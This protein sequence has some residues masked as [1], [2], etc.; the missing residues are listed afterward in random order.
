MVRLALPWMLLL[1]M[2]CALAPGQAPGAATPSRE[3]AIPYAQ[4]TIDGELA[5]WPATAARIK[6][7]DAAQV[8]AGSGPWNGP[9]D[10]AA[11]LWL[12]C[13]T[14]HLYLA[15]Q[16]Q[17]DQ[18]LANSD[19]L[20]AGRV[21]R[22]EVAFRIQSEQ[23]SGPPQARE[24]VWVLSPLLE[25][26]P[27]AWLES[28]RDGVRQY[29][30]SWAGVRVQ[31]K[32]LGPNRYQWEAA[33]P[34]HHL[35]GL[36]P[37]S[38]RLGCQMALF[39]ADGTEGNQ[40]TV[41]RWPAAGEDEFGALWLPT[42]GPL[43]AAER[44]AA[45]VLPLAL[46]DLPLLLVPL[47][48][49][50]ALLLLWRLWRWLSR[51]SRRLRR[52]LILAGV[53]LL[54]A[55]LALPALLTSQRAADQRQAVAAVFAHLQQNVGWFAEGSL[56]SFRGPSRD[57]ALVDLLSGRRIVRQR[58]M[59]Y[60]PLAA[61]LPGQFGPPVRNVDDLPVQPYWL[62]LTTDRPESFQFEPALQGSQLHLVL[63]RPFVPKLPFVRDSEVPRLRLELGYAT[64]EP[65]VL[66]VEVDRSFLDAAGLGSDFAE[67]TVVPVRLERDLRSLSVM[68]Q[69]GQDLRL[70]GV[71]LERAEQ[72]QIEPLMLGTV[73]QGGVPTDLRGP[74]PREA[75]I[76]LLPGATARVELPTQLEPP[77]KLWFFHSATYPGVPT[78]NPGARVAE[79]MLHF[80]GGRPAQ[81]LLLEHQVSMFYELALNNTRIAPPDGSPAAIGLSWV[82]DRKELHVN[83][84]QPVLDLPAGA[85]L[86]AI[87]FRN[88]GSYRIRFRSVILGNERTV[89]PQDPPNSPL[90]RDGPERWLPPEFL[91]ELASC[92]VSIYRGER[93]SETTASDR[94]LEPTVLPRTAAASGPTLLETTLRDGSRRT[95]ILA[96]LTGE[97]WDAAVL[98]VSRIDTDWPFARQHYSRIGLVLC[99]LAA[100][101]LLILLSELL[102]IASNLR[103]RL[104][105]VL[106]VAAL[107][108]L[109]VLSLVLV[110]VIESG[111]TSDLREGMRAS[112]RTVLGQIEDQKERVRTSAQQWLRDLTLTVQALREREPAL[113]TGAWQALAVQN[114]QKLLAGQLPPEWRGG[115]L[116]L[117]WQPAERD[118]IPDPLVILA[119]DLRMANL[120]TP[121]RLDPGVF[122]QWG[123]MLLGI[124][125]EE[126]TRLGT[127]QL[128]AGRPM[129]D[130]LLGAMAPGQA[131][132]LTDPRGYPLAVGASRGESADWWA[133]ARDPGIMAQRERALRRGLESQR[134]LVDLVPVRQQ[135]FV[136]GSEVLRDLQDTPRALL[137]LL[138]PDQR[139]ALDLAVGRVPVRMFFWLAGGSLVVMVG[140]LA[141]LVSGRIGTPLERLDGFLQGLLQGERG[142]R[143][144]AEDH[145][146]LGRLTRN[147]NQLAAALQGRE[148]DL[149]DLHRTTREL[150]QR[151]H[152]AAVLQQ[153]LEFCSA[154][155][156]ADAVAVAFL[157]GEA[158]RCVLPN[159]DGETLCADPALPRVFAT[160]IGAF[161]AVPARGALRS[162]W[163]ELLPSAR[164]MLGLPLAQAG[165]TR[166]VLLLGFAR[167]E[168]L[169]V[170]LDLLGLVVA[171]AAT[172]LERLELQRLA[173]QD[174]ATGAYTVEYFRRRVA[175]EL[176]LAQ[177]QSRPLV[178]VG[179]VLG[180]GERRPRGLRRLLATV[181]AQLPAEALL[182]HDAAGCVQVALPGMRR[183]QGEALLEQVAK[184][185]TES[186]DSLPEN[187]VEMQH[188]LGVVVEY[189]TEAP[190]A[191]LLFDALRERL[192]AARAPGALAMESDESLQRAG[193]TAI[194]PAMREVYSM[195]R[196]VAPTDLPLLLEGETGV[197]KE[198]L[199]KLV[200]GWSRRA[201]GP[202]VRVHCAA[203]SETLLA[204]ELFGHEKGAFTGAERRKIG[205][206]E[207]ADGGTLFLDEVGEIPLEV[208]V[209]LLRVLQ[210][211][212]I[213]RVGGTEP[214]K[215]NVRVV[216][217]TNRDIARLVAEGRF[218]EDLYYRLQ[219][220]V[221]R[222]PPLR[223][224][225]QELGVLVEHFRREM[226]AAGQVQVRTISTDAMDALYRHD[227]PGNI[228]E[229]RNTVFRAMVMARDGVV[230]RRDIVAALSVGTSTSAS[231]STGE[232]QPEDL[233]L[234]ASLPG[235]AAAFVPVDPGA[236]AQ[237]IPPPAS[238]LGEVEAS[239]D[240]RAGGLDPTAPLLPDLGSAEDAQHLEGRL[241]D[242]YDLALQHGSITS[243]LHQQHAGVSPRTSL[244][245]LQNLVKIG[246]L[247]RV[248][249][250]RGAYYRPK[251]RA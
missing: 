149:Q 218:R 25:S 21:D 49:L 99:L 87:E 57:R 69:H 93:L 121:A 239:P 122:L 45:F 222:V 241:R 123:T 245:D 134:S 174:P 92:A 160:T 58:S 41:L 125:A 60:R 210:E 109:V 80:R 116:R 223:E 51:R 79:I 7:N 142:A 182:S 81:R 91:A 66:Q 17:D 137:L 226:V 76:E 11:E 225:R 243:E 103:L 145:G 132:L 229:L 176:A 178:L 200:H 153:L 170:D 138:Q 129:D 190:S 196:R 183:Q 16:I 236:A 89:A 29:G 100:P 53:L 141:F 18:I 50:A 169:P 78:A 143:V 188:P 74:Y 104:M 59:Q 180:D 152:S 240:G 234:P 156:A 217:A 201:G 251:P 136:Q 220:M 106:S 38:L 101:W 227:W 197:G 44:S 105:I 126:T 139:A 120:E 67:V 164:S 48:T 198:V 61:L 113:S 131:V 24:A 97:G 111:H 242:L 157:D 228:R 128:T 65:R 232:R 181:R 161:C 150:A 213:D 4:V 30:S 119:G 155:T 163:R 247:E 3:L 179:L 133:H 70:V 172:S 54:A 40:G 205:R 158:V 90:L 144:E 166:G 202:L 83:L 63:G 154:H 199:T 193:V 62:P 244:R 95:T 221:V 235:H 8:L 115:F 231:T 27:W 167:L 110:R 22:L 168:P 151:T 37:G 140:F 9:E 127:F 13:D 162:P 96:P 211:Q 68:V 204:S 203:L 72:G 246:L 159:R 86:Q 148:Q 88:L 10:L 185:W 85:E 208:Q 5:D 238:V 219:G 175:D 12:A 215:V 82:D 212:E 249:S 52:W 230:E 31:A 173:I 36:R 209:K 14:N 46:A 73:S 248:G 189:P 118:P 15:A 33:L 130:D 171:Q 186:L 35:P 165:R 23:D 124:R 19:D 43:V 194:S 55:G 6:L 1:G 47:A 39:E 147:C 135:D 42:P 28:G 207:Q 233:Q 71:S 102:A 237:V 2:L 98:S 108:P 94:S 112:L 187:E 107:V 216:A 146:Q 191:E 117:E 56:K 214:V 206:F 195:L 77:Q 64:G 184:A 84:V 32:R 26:R 114:L 224:R 34:F 192:L 20:A 75:G 177:Q 250:R